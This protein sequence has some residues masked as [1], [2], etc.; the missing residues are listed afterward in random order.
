M[1]AHTVITTLS[2][3]IAGS[4]AA[5]NLTSGSLLSSGTVQ[6]GAYQTAY[7][8][9]KTFV[10]QFNNTGKVQIITAGSI[11]G[12]NNTWT[13]LSAANGFSGINDQYYVSGFPMGNALAMT[14]DTQH[15]YDEAKASGREF[16]LMGYNLIDGPVAGPLGR[17]PWGGRQPE[18]FAADPY[19]TGVAYNY[20][21]A[22]MNAAGV[23]TGGR[24]YLLNE[25][26]TNRSSA[27]G[28]STSSVYSSNADDKTIHELYLWP[29]A[30]GT[31]AGM[32][33]VMCAMTRTNGTL[34]CEN[35]KLLDGLLK[36]ELGFPGMVYPDINGQSTTFGS[37]NGGLDRG[38]SNYWSLDIL[39][40]G[41]A[42]GS[43]TQARLDDMAI[44]NVIGYFYAGL[45]DGKQPSVASTTEYR[46]VR[47]DHA[48]LIRKVAED[49]LVLLKNNVTGGGGLPLNKPLTIS[50]F[51]AHA[52][53]AIA[54]PNQAFSVQGSSG[55]IYQGH[56]ASAVGSGQLS[57]SYLRTPYDAL[58][59]RA[60]ADGSMF[61]WILN[62]TYTESDSSMGMGGGF[63]VGVPP[64]GSNSSSMGGAPGGGADAPSI[65]GAG[66]TVTPS[67]ENYAEDTDV[68]LV[69]LNAFSG[70][71][72]DREELYNTDQDT[73]VNTIAD[74]CNNTIVVINTVGPRLV[75][76]WIE[77][78]N[79][80]ALLYGGLLGQESG[81]A[82]VD[83]LYGD[84]N[85]SGKMINT[86]AKNE[87]DYPV[88]ICYTAQCNFTEGVHI[89]Y[90][91]FDAYNITPRYEFGYGLSYTAFEYGDV[92]V[93]KTNSSA[94]SFKYPTGPLTLGGY[95]DLFDEVISVST[96]VKN[97]GSVDGAEVAQLYV[98]Y[99]A[100]AQQPP[101]QLRGF[102][103]ANITT[104]ATE[105]VSF[106][107]R[108]R[109]VSYWD[110]VAQ[111]WAIANG[112]YTFSVGSSSRD[113]RGHATLTL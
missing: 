30:D 80:T 34:S 21:V 75:E 35:S 28:A 89:D 72:A 109:D 57:F 41:I 91:Y 63:G 111:Q 8:K 56:L 97:T 50:I 15:M 77:H 47:S 44:R 93:S 2:T 23:V 112:T 4:R 33:A 104:G 9:A 88:S 68:C 36:E 99:P 54:G 16:Y 94:L 102:V 24:H 32:G 55:P 71:G 95:D 101:R 49:S 59:L 5:S 46:S 40:A 82:I 108:R 85:P 38:S 81:A 43:F 45:D 110:V 42:N 69:F 12:G 106:G 98:A 39:E 7:E 51:G 60:A 3:L 79:V 103:K 65:A 31:R 74:N 84:V 17:T 11:T 107:V 83:A 14:W 25:Q 70:E 90:R 87:S 66:T 19:L 20:T 22:G 48:K 26:E 29:F 64:S 78:E 105:Q 92:T 52:G 62:N 1:R 18:A 67:F 73:L 61:R 37:A 58:N 10:A 76:S 13:A 100:I 27:L 113:L 53:P 96:S 86:V 6:L